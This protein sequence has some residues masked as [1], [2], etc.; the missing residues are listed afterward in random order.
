MVLAASTMAANARF[1][2]GNEQVPQRAL[3][4]GVGTIMDAREVCI[5]ANGK[6]KADAV[7]NA[8][9]G[10]VSSRW[11]ISKLQ[12]H[13]AWWLCVDEE[14]SCKLSLETVEVCCCCLFV[15]LFSKLGKWG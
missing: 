11:T 2:V 12:D 10:G 6:G 3:T 15:C 7:V 8:V 9:E 13:P 14:A 1:F 5:V 4:V